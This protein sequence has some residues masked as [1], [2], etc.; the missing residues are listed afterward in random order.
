[1]PA[2]RWI[3]ILSRVTCWL[4]LAWGLLSIPAQAAGF[5]VITASSRLE[6]GVYR[7]NARLEYHFQQASA[8]GAGKRRTAH[9]RT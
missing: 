5:E 2:N 9:D 7:L 8:G 6:G 1:M 4:L 3:G